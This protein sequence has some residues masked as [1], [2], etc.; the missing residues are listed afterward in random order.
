MKPP[1]GAEGAW[2]NETFERSSDYREWLL[3]GIARPE[4]LSESHA[5]KKLGYKV[6]LTLA[7]APVHIIGLDSAWLCG[8]DNDAKKI[9][10][11]SDQIDQATTQDG[12]PLSG[13]RLAL[14]HHP[15]EELFDGAQSIRL[16]SERVDLVLHG[17]QHAPNADERF[18]LDQGLRVLAAGC[19]YEGDE[20]D[21]YPNAFNVVEVHLNDEGRP[22]KY[23]LQFWGWSENGHWYRTGA[24]YK[25]APAGRVTWW[26]PLGE[27][28]RSTPR[29]AN[30]TTDSF[31]GRKSE[32]EECL[33]SVL[34]RQ[35]VTLVGPGGIGKTR[36]ACEVLRRLSEER[37]FRDGIFF[38]D[39]VHTSE[40][41]KRGLIS[42]IA[43]ALG[44]R[45]R[46][47]NEVEVLEAL[48][49]HRMLIV[50][51]NFET[52]TNGAPFVARLMRECPELHLLVTSQIRL[53]VPAEESHG[54]RPME[55]PRKNGAAISA[56]LAG[57]DCFQLFRDRVRAAK[58]NKSWDVTEANV[59]PIKEIL[60]LTEGIPLAIELV[61]ARMGQYSPSEIVSNR[62]KHIEFL[63]NQGVAAEDRHASITASIEWSL[64]LLPRPTQDLFPKLSVFAGGFFSRDVDEVCR[65]AD[66]DEQLRLLHKYSLLV[67]EEVQNASRF[68]MLETVRK[69]AAKKLGEEI[70]EPAKLKRRH[71]TYFLK[72]LTQ[73]RDRLK[74]ND[75]AL[76][77]ARITAEY[78]NIIAGL[79]TSR[80]FKEHDWVIEYATHLAN[81]LSL[82]GRFEQQKTISEQAL[83]AAKLLD[84][85]QKIA[86]TQNLLGNA[87]SQF[88]GDWGENVERAISYYL[89]ALSVCTE[90]SQI[91]AMTKNNLG[92]AY[93]DLLTGNRNANLVR[94][95]RCYEN[96]LRVYAKSDSPDKWAMTQNNLGTAYA[97]LS[98]GDKGE[99]L[100]R[101]IE[102]Y[103]AA[104]SVR[105]K[106]D[107][108]LAWAKT[109]YNVGIACSK[110]P[111]GEPKEN[112]EA[113]IGY[114]KAAL[115][116]R[117]EQDFPRD[118]AM[119]QKA[120][121]DVYRARVTGVRT[122]NL[123]DAISCYEHALRIYTD[124]EDALRRSIEPEFR[125]EWGETQRDLGAAYA[126]LRDGDEIENLKRAIACSQAALR[127]YEAPLIPVE[128]ATTQHNLGTIYSN[129]L[130]GG[131]ADNLKRAINCFASGLEVRTENERP[132]EFAET[133]YN[134][135]R[136]YVQL[137]KGRNV[138]LAIAAY[139]AAAR[140]YAAA[141]MADKA[142]EALERAAT[143]N[144]HLG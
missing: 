144:E 48:R 142:S 44:D 113:A 140:G 135:A 22:L 85:P 16:L 141:T 28:T 24:V 105:T 139:K 78:E 38:V 55:I 1:D 70:G 15:L 2:L 18:D 73:E 3:H 132:Q 75:Q 33:N 130:L 4:L 69:C 92:N 114:F 67:R 35:L 80:E 66:A 136:T 124:P 79:E 12:K 60:F 111:T 104:L 34:G 56:G 42:A 101:A 88:P 25:A 31:V 17:H 115:E 20:G 10:L 95:I 36:I 86:A 127:I 81:Y 133:Q 90:G 47:D 32:V 59:E 138:E 120:L 54:I 93:C 76:G 13:F 5:H 103:K 72:I 61:A 94:A 9:L 121:G 41:S 122:E 109:Q 87:Y 106:R 37:D 74:K 26:T 126:D 65:I 84:D 68:K 29:P 62:Q 14:V 119:T 137:G 129:P 91:W 52:V 30:S 63:K 51:D 82:R 117:T 143:L 118:W 7:E 58:E 19:L 108:P 131:S 49:N 100:K 6:D 102:F 96:A 53:L 77:F 64:N 125:L 128:F 27:R 83:S 57:F 21:Q 99:N 123:K 98:E 43:A 46:G 11:T 23:E 134:L 97:D 45:V 110:L 40:N 39:L 50:L 107:S 116:V 8:D 112:L 89:E 71:A